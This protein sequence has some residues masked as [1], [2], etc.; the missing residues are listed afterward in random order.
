MIKVMESECVT[1][2]EQGGWCLQWR[3]GKVPCV[4]VRMYFRQ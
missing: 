3:L 2:L 1:T 4:W